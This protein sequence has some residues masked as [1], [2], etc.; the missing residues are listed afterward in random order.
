MARTVFYSH[1]SLHSAGNCAAVLYD[2]SQ[3]TDTKTNNT[4]TPSAFKI[5]DLNLRSLEVLLGRWFK[6]CHPGY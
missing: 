1:P 3:V 5:P 4:I 2:L 6:H